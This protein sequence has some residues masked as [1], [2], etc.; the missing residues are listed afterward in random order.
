M[1]F[2]NRIKHKN[3]LKVWT[4]IE[5]CQNF[6]KISKGGICINILSILSD[7]NFSHQKKKVTSTLSNVFSP[8]SQCI[9]TYFLCKFMI[10]HNNVFSL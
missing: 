10:L 3:H 8:W 9:F 7:F 2:I 1:L 5:Y 6:L 4:N